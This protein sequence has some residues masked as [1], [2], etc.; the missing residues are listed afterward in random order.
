MRNKKAII[1]SNKGA[2]P[3]LVKNNVN[4]YIFDI[5]N[6]S[7]LEGI[8]NNLNKKTL[9]TLGENGYEVFEK[10]FTSDKM[11]RQIINLYREV[12]L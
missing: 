9:K 12:L 6:L 7:T 3:E 1:A 2:L 11:N 8:V 4:G 5:S 10:N